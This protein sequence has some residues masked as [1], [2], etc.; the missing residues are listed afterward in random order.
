VRAASGRKYALA[1][2]ASAS[3]D[4]HVVAVALLPEMG[5]SA[6]AIR[7]THLLDDCPNVLHLLMVGIAGAVP[8]PEK[9]EQHVRLGDIVVSDRG[10]VIQYDLVKET[11]DGVIQHRNAPR[12]PS[13]EL[14]EAVNWLRSDEDLGN[15]PWELFIDRG[16]DRLGSTWHRPAPEED[17]LDDTVA[18]TALVSHPDDSDRRPGHPR[19]FHG[20]IAAA[21]VLL[22]NA[23]RRDDLRGKFGVKAVE[24]EGSG[25]A[26]AAWDGRVGYLVIRGT[27][28]YCNSNKNDLWQKYSA[29]IAAAYARV[30][31]ASIPAH[32][33]IRPRH[34][35]L[36]LTELPTGPTP[37]P[38]LR[39][40]YERAFEHGRLEAQFSA[41]AILEPSPSSPA[42]RID[43]GVQ[44]SLP[45]IADDG[46]LSSSTPREEFRRIV[47]EVRAHLD[48]YDHDLAREAA[49][50]LER[51][52]KEH[53]QLFAEANRNEAY[54]LLI[55]VEII[56]FKR[57]RQDSAPG[58][59]TAR[60]REILG[61]VKDLSD[62][63][64]VS[65]AGLFA[66]EA[67]L[68]SLEQGAEE[69]LARLQGR[70]DPQAM[71]RR[72]AILLDH[73]RFSEAA[74]LAR[75]RTPER[76]WCEKAVSAFVHVGE[77]DRAK[78]LIRWAGQQDDPASR[79]RSILCYADSRLAAAFRGR[80][81]DKPVI[82]GSVDQAERLAL[83]DVL[84]TLRPVL[85]MVQGNGRISDAL[86]EHAVR[87][88]LQ[89][90]ILLGNRA[91]A[92]TLSTLVATRRPVPLV[93]A[94]LVLGA[95]LPADGDLPRRLRKEH[96]G[97]YEAARLALLLEAK[98]PGKIAEAFEE[99]LRIDVDALH[100][101]HRPV[102]FYTLHALA[103][104]IGEEAMKRVERLAPG[105]LAPDLDSLKLFL[106][107]RYLVSNN[108]EAARAI[109]EE[110]RAEDDPRWLQLYGHLMH[111]SGQPDAAMQRLLAASQRVPE[112]D[113]FRQIGRVAYG[114]GRYDIVAEA[115]Q[116]VLAFDPSD[117]RSRVNYAGALIKIGDASGAAEQFRVLREKAPDDPWHALNE[118]A[119][120]GHSGALEAGL[121][122]YEECCRAAAPKLEAIL[123]RAETLKLLDRLSDAFLS[124][125]KIRD[126]WWNEP[127]FVLLYMSVAY[128]AGMDRQGSLALGRLVELQRGT[129][130]TD[131]ILTAVSLDDL[132]KTFAE[133]EAHD[134]TV[135]EYLLCG[136]VP[137]IMVE[138]GRRRVPYLGWYIRTQ[139]L[140]WCPDSRQARA[141]LSVYATNGF[142][143]ID[144]G[145]SGKDVVRTECPEAGT[146]VAIDLSALYTLHALG[147]LDVAAGYFGKLMIPAVY[148]DRVLEERSRL[149]PHQL[150][151]RTS[152]KQVR[153]AI[154]LGRISVGTEGSSNADGRTPLVDE[155]TE[156]PPEGTTLYRVL[157]LIEPLHAVGR[158]TAVDFDR[159]KQ[160]F[161]RHTRPRTRATAPALFSR[162]DADLFTLLAIAQVGCLDHV[163]GSFRIAISRQAAAEVARRLREHS[164]HDSVR[165]AHADL[166]ARI[167]ADGRY[168][169]T[170]VIEPTD[171][172]KVG[173][174]ERAATTTTLGSSW[175]AAQRGIP[176][177]VDGRVIQVVTNTETS[178]REPAAFS[179]DR[180]IEK[181]AKVGAIPFDQSVDAM[182]QLMRW[183]YRFVLPSSEMLKGLL[184]RY[185]A[186]PPGL[187]LR[188]VAEYVHDCMRDPGL[189]SGFEPT[190]PPTSMASRLRQGWITTVAQFVM[191]VW[192]D[193]AWPE[194]SAMEVTTWATRQLLPSPPTTM[195][196]LLQG[197]CA[198]HEHRL[199]ISMALIASSAVESAER[200]NAGLLA[201]AES[202]GIRRRDLHDTL[203]DV[204][205]QE[206]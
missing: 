97:S 102:H 141:E 52:L 39:F 17:V 180:L 149:V 32:P 146:Q 13:S 162:L 8:H 191:D 48:S 105:L 164:F 30:L 200:A 81:T 7:A 127:R 132:R 104:E 205:A 187:G 96:P 113:L 61:A 158:I 43:D 198:R 170:P 189:F 206:E 12:P 194:A 78:E 54:A 69:G 28:D 145:N 23:A 196:G 125:D 4:R 118:A 29:I 177:L 144:G 167:R 185:R 126:S 109:L 133:R 63:S 77:I 156:D 73:E 80:G 58:A 91:E 24:M 16:V 60:A 87:L 6:A 186:N 203:A 88:A 84:Q 101:K 56:E 117:V 103:Q 10:G 74:T 15:R 129:V 26:D 66:A 64:T 130:A 140:D 176:L 204:I 45:A 157:D 181:L 1:E 123:G 195:P 148:L 14:L 20:P 11:G 31:I 147:L 138:D 184:D 163:V 93:L 159:V 76:V 165:A 172:I 152:L 128:A 34:S 98:A 106:A 188:E 151:Q 42:L 21:N 168:A 57:L 110:L 112:A 114:L 38:D 33:R 49:R 135:S 27:C 44:R 199:I 83:S 55:D 19:V 183:R 50:D 193:R 18:G 90:E 47:K 122:V 72:L 107:D 67:Y 190:T 174:L 182:L 173:S 65:N 197:A 59:S 136:Q 9:A 155:Y 143:L 53:L 153:S 36:D 171:L 2:I 169:I 79:R 160:A 115:M 108:M 62:D 166:W 22:K 68:H 100:K 119:S 116:K 201:I 134:A 161:S 51:L 139:P 137:W 86:E 99:A 40:L 5:N 131:E 3:G 121:S 85:L 111:R 46:L 75:E 175:I 150:S 94:E 142:Q 41:D 89:S 35:G 82:P 70:D 154:D 25:I 178:A 192:G 92:E 120:L 202:L 37:H 179:T 95:N 71:R 124:L